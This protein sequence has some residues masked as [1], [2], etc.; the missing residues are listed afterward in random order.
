[1]GK[2]RAHERQ[3]GTR[4]QTG[5]NAELAWQELQ[6]ALRQELARL[7]EKYRA[8][9]VLCCLEGK[10]GAEAA[11][12]LGWKEGTVT[13]RLTVARQRLRAALARRGVALP[14][15]LCGTALFFDGSGLPA[16]LPAAT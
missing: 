2:R 6:A 14:A 15:A 13:G 3:V 9:F 5:P 1:M 16:A 4:A 11:R 10:S 8:P 7:P 12:D